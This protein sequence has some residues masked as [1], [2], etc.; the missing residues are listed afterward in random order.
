ML[1]GES[2][3]EW[4]E[5]L[6]RSVEKFYDKETNSIIEGESVCPGCEKPYIMDIDKGY[7]VCCPQH[8]LARTEGSKEGW[9]STWHVE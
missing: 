7:Y 2:V 1:P 4:L 6:D 9:R 3:G 5:R 8:Y